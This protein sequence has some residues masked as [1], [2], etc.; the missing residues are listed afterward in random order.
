M[1]KIIATS[2][3]LLTG[4]LSLSAQTIVTSDQSVKE[5]L[6]KWRISASVGGAYQY[7]DIPDGLNPIE[8]EHA[9]ALQWGLTY[10]ADITHYFFD[11]YGV[12]IKYNGFRSACRQNI[13]GTSQASGERVRGEFSDVINIWF[14]GP[15]VSSREFTFGQSGFLMNLGFGYMGYHDDAVLIDPFT[16][17]GATLGMMAE[18][19]YELALT[20]TLKLHALF[21]VYAG[22]LRSMTVTRAGYSSHYNLDKDEYVSLG[23]FDLKAGLSFNF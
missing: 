4:I 14:V 2:L 10:D 20:K 11:T 8:R 7:G 23:H 6:S 5:E 22:T 1:K 19:G 13:E 17:N 15:M 18:G 12:G 9:K 3:L 21:S 16:I